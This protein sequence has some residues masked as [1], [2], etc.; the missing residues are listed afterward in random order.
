[1]IRKNTL[2]LFHLKL[3]HIDTSTSKLVAS[4]FSIEKK[5]IDIHM[6][7]ASIKFI[8]NFSSFHKTSIKLSFNSF[9]DR[10]E[11]VKSAKSV[12]DLICATSD[13]IKTKRF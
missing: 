7:I 2:S 9:E 5:M 10:E 3:V 11:V 1:M 13:S 8:K 6:I 12:D 4:M